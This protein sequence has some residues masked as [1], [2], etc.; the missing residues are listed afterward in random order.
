MKGVEQTLL[1]TLGEP[2]RVSECVCVCVCV[3]VYECV[4]ACDKAARV[5][6]A[7][8]GRI[9]DGTRCSGLTTSVKVH[10]CT[11]C[12]SV[13]ASLWI[14]IHVYSYTVKR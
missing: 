6:Y 3:C 1:V 9:R 11:V 4:H 5:Q 13:H 12:A 14:S 2:A 10:V 7:Q 8:K